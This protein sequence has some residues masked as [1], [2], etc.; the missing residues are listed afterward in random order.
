[1][2][3]GFQQDLLIKQDTITTE[4]LREYVNLTP[5]EER[6]IA[7]L[8]EEFPLKVSRYFAEKLKDS[9]PDFPLRKMVI[10]HSDELLTYDDDDDMSL[11]ADESQYQPVE[12]LIHRYPGKVL[13][14]PVLDCFANCRFCYRKEQQVTP[15]IE[16]EKVDA[17]IEY[18]RK[19]EEIRDVII[20]GGDPFI[21]SNEKLDELVGRVR[22]IPHVEIIRIGTR[23]LSF[24][25]NRIDD[26]LANRLAKHAP[27]IVKNSYLHAD[28]MTPES[29]EACR[30]LADRGIMLFQQGPVLKG[31]NDS[32]A[33]LKRLYE[34][35]IKNR[36]IPYYAGFGVYAKGARHFLLQEHEVV[37]LMRP[38]EN[39]TSGFCIPT[40]LGIDHSNGK[41]RY[42]V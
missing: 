38:L 16:K 21:L 34:T 26:D 15:L 12:G 42:R 32:T 22:A 29:A 40:L 37:D 10:P 6:A 18:I 23:V 19:T 41:V 14:F 3:S 11:H 36:V 25:P 20:T 39:N 4:E 1:M 24:E 17:A 30:K 9:S 35:L 2:S 27:L 31:I 33:E 8:S 13:F 7:A 28:E 5:E